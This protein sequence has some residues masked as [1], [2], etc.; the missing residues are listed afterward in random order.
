MKKKTLFLCL[1]LFLVPVLLYSLVIP[2][3]FNAQAVFQ[4]S[5]GTGFNLLYDGIQGLFLFLLAII[6][7]GK[8]DYAQI[9]RCILVF[10]I[11]VLLT[12]FLY[13]F[14]SVP[15]VPLIELALF[16]V[17]LFVLSENIFPRQRF[18]LGWANSLF[19]GYV[20][21]VSLAVQKQELFLL[22]TTQAKTEVLL[23]ALFGI[24]LGVVLSVALLVGISILLLFFLLR[25]PWHRRYVLIPL[26]LL[27]FV[28]FGFNVIRSFL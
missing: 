23:S 21:G 4:R 5:V 26:N 7:G 9:I 18:R 27:L 2:I 15:A 10:T 19:F 13:I 12:F 16:F 28:L 8:R 20:F 14:Y 1:I 25:K 6:F 24:S 22:L 3:R 17:A 11:S